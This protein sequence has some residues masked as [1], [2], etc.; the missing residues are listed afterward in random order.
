MGKKKEMTCEEWELQEAE[1]RLVGD[2]RGVAEH[3]KNIDA[4]WVQLMDR[5]QGLTLIGQ[6]VTH[7]FGIEV[8]EKLFDNSPD[9]IL[10]PS[11]SPSNIKKRLSG[12][13]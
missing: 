9:I 2:L 7:K 12:V 11:V 6:P 4:T 5:S 8:R 13:M 1:R 10:Y 3:K